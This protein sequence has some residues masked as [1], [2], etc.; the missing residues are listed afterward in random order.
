M[1]RQLIYRLF[2]KK[3]YMKMSAQD[4][5]RQYSRHHYHD[6]ESK[7]LGLFVQA[8]DICLDVGANLGSYAYYISEIVGEKG[9]VYAFE[10]VVETFKALQGNIAASRLTNV[11][12]QN[13][14]ISNRNGKT[15]IFMPK[16]DG[17]PSHG[18]AYLSE[19][20]TKETGECQ[21]VVVTTIDDFYAASGLDRVDFIK[22]DIEGAELLAVQGAV[23]V[24]SQHHPVLLLEVEPRYTERFGYEPSDIFSLLHAQ[25]YTEVF[26]W[27]GLTLTGIGIDRLAQSNHANQFTR[28]LTNQPIYNFYIVHPDKVPGALHIKTHNP[29]TR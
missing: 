5:R 16:I 11:Y 6:S 27:N 13:M 8:G 12:A 14:G 7:L 19:Q 20:P 25:G 26:Y 29:D 3:A 1:I 10:P 28:G 2:G 22:M 24:I 17:L 15:R 9:V 21:D 23:R 4:Q 18:R